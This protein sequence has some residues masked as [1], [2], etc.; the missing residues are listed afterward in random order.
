MRASEL[1][2][3]SVPCLALRVTYVGE[4]GWELYCPMGVRPAPLGHD[5]GRGPRARPAAGGYK[6]IDSL[7]PRKGLQGLGRRHHSD[8]TPYE[9]ALDFAV[10]LDKG[11]FIGREALLKL[12]ARRS[13]RKSHASSSRM[14]VRLRSA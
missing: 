6:A 12:R 3:G 4:L 7:R 8:E 9:A 11:D 5:L 10:K 1:A 14:L 2:V 13:E